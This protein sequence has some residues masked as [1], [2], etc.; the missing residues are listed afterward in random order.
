MVCW[1]RRTFVL[2]L[3]LSCVAACASPGAPKPAGADLQAGQHN[4]AEEAGLTYHLGGGVGINAAHD[5][6][7]RFEE[8]YGS[9]LPSFVFDFET[10]FPGDWFLNATGEYGSTS[11]REMLVTGDE[12]DT[13]LSLF[14]AHFSVG[15][16]LELRP[17]WQLAAG[18]GATISTYREVNDIVA[19]DGTR[20]GGH[21]LAGIRWHR[22]RWSL[23]GTLRYTYVPD[24]LEERQ[25]GQAV[26]GR[27]DLG[28]LS[29]A[30]AVQYQIWPYRPATTGA[31]SGA[32]GQEG[33]AGGPG[34]PAR[35]DQAGHAAEW[36]V[37][38]GRFQVQIYGAGV[39]PTDDYR[40][41]STRVRNLTASVDSS[42]GIGAGFHA[43]LTGPLGV[44]FDAIFAWPGIHGSLDYPYAY[45]TFYAEG[46]LDQKMFALGLDLHLLE[47][48][49]VDLY[50][51]PLASYISYKGE[52]TGEY[53]SRIDS[54]G[55]AFGLG[56]GAD[57]GHGRW[58]FHT[59]FKHLSVARISGFETGFN[60][61][62]VLLTFGLGYRF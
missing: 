7:T 44:G 39:F 53:T 29:L 32:P 37:D 21:G 56:V 33:P 26:V 57:I 24:G 11:G 47:H 40:R 49:T 38:R 43:R 19:S 28:Y 45:T 12:S 35:A 34:P 30:F 55:Y 2:S 23:N 41:P 52:L 62:P 59:S 61:R 3:A 42:L 4:P 27:H 36:M 8:V 17:E 58:V 51:A 16:I 9:A 46:E 60:V 13:K 10:R 54:Q 5:G 25:G 14:P 20:V 6:G 48:Q 50:V 1:V 15:K 22:K 18:G 31:R